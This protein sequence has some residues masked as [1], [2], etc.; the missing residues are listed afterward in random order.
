MSRK[1]MASKV[2]DYFNGP[3]HRSALTLAPAR[4]GEEFGG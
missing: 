1:S 3:I 2:P 4:N